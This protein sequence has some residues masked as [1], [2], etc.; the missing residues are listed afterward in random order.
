MNRHRDQ[1]PPARESAALAADDLAGLELPALALR[2]GPEQAEQTGSDLLD[3]DRSPNLGTLIEQGDVHSTAF[4]HR[5][6]STG[7]RIRLAPQTPL[8]LV[9]VRSSLL[10]PGGR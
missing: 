10:R 7:K 8:S 4:A 3:G 1:R 2:H 6:A 9:P 5:G